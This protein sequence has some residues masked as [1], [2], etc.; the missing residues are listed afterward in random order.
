MVWAVGHLRLISIAR[1]PKRSTWIVAPD[2][3]QNGPDTPKFHAT[4]DD[5]RSVAA[6]VHWETMTD[7]VRPVLTERPAVL[8]NSD[9]TLPE[10]LNV[11]SRY[12]RST[13]RSV[14]PTPMPTTMI[15]PDAWLRGALPPK[16]ESSPKY[17]RGMCVRYGVPDESVGSV[18]QVSQLTMVLR[19]GLVG[20]V[21]GFEGLLRRLRVGGSAEAARIQTKIEDVFRGASGRLWCGRGGLLGVGGGVRWGW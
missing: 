1:M 14:M 13:A 11:T 5:W 15:Q 6:Q 3:Y 18:T 9:E 7:A 2:A 20:F 4:L 8:K 16:K 21:V 19:K 17:S 12:V 10:R